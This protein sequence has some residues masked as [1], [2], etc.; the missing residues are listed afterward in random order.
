LE[1]PT[2]EF[3]IMQS[4]STVQLPA[5][6]N[7][8][9]TTGY[10][11]FDELMGNCGGVFGLRAGKIVLL[12]AQS[13]TGKTRLCLSLGAALIAKDPNLVYGHFTGE[14][15]V[16]ALAM[17][18][19]SMGIAFGQNV[20]AGSESHWE[21]IEKEII[22]HNIKIVVIDSFPMLTFNRHPETNKELDTKQKCKKIADF[23]EL[24]GLSMILLNH[25][26]KKGNRAG[27]NELMHLVDVAYTMSKS[28]MEEVKVIKFINDKNR[29]GTP[30]NR[31]FP[32]C[33]I[34]DL[35]TPFAVVEAGENETGE[36]NAGKVAQR[37]A[38]K[39]ELLIE[40][41]EANDGVLTREELDSGAFEIE[42]IVTSA[43]KSMLREL[44]SEGVLE[45]VTESKGKRGTTPI[46]LWKIAA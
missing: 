35:A 11:S 18:G 31:A 20:L 41:I 19:R 4:L 8:A 44:V 14:Q 32:F 26:D 43:L 25:T 30:V 40:S 13:G 39:R 28:I 46:K 33:G 7:V 22:A 27:R 24:H 16:A 6:W 15:S 42:G 29:E 17:T 34:W 10:D 3:K 5:N 2:T 23:T 1:T 45:A 37:K 38:E 12:S 9:L 21:N 36:Q